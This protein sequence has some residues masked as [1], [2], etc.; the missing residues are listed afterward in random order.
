MRCCVVSS[1]VSA[2]L[3]LNYELCAAACNFG[4]FS[5]CRFRQTLL[6]YYIYICMLKVLRVANCTF[7]CS[8]CAWAWPGLRL[9][10]ICNLAAYRFSDTHQSA[11]GRTAKWVEYGNKILNMAL[12]VY[13]Y[14][15]TGGIWSF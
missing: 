11:F 2:I 14:F 13:G 5:F 9:L 15:E 6:T 10:P 12:F 7:T 3:A 8:T 4:F 1:T